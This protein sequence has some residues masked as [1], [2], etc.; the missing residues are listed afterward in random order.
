[1]TGWFRTLLGRLQAPWW[2]MLGLGL[3]ALLALPVTLIVDAVVLFVR[4][5]RV[6]GYVQATEVVC[7]RG[8]VVRVRGHSALWTCGSCGYGYLGS[9]FAPCPRCRAVA[10]FVQCSC[11][12][13][14]RN[15]LFEI[16]GDRDAR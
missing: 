11:G 1:M 3:L 14:V 4:S 2:A 9:G 15:P 16:L 13:S 10:G 12:A 8:H 6:A 5:V 7:P